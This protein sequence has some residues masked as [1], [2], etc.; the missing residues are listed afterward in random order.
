M[1]VKTGIT[2]ILIY[3]DKFPIFQ[4][5]FSVRVNMT[6]EINRTFTQTLMDPGSQD[7]KSLTDGF[8]YEVCDKPIKT[9]T[10]QCL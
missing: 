2:I 6:V 3:D 8:C 9:H 1:C 7:Y 4:I 5:L 10:V